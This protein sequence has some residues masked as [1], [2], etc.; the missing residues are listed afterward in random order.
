MDVPSQAG[1][2]GAITR[3]ASL[4]FGLLGATLGLALGLAGGLARGSRPGAIEGCVGGVDVR[5]VAGAVTTPA[6]LPI[7]FQTIK[8][9]PLASGLFVPLMC[10]AGSGRRWVR[11]AASP[12]GSGPGPA[13]TSS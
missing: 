5:G 12:S 6:L 13:G 7:Y 10:M 1:E 9:D 2:H 3:N 11:W 4:A 8:E